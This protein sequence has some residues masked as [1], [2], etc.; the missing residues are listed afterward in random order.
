MTH[1]NKLTE[2]SKISAKG[3]IYSYKDA[4]IKNKKYLKPMNKIYHDL[5]N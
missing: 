3:E 5:G 1:N 4:Y 2:C